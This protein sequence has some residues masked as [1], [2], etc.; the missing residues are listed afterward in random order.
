MEGTET[1]AKPRAGFAAGFFFFLVFGGIMQR[2]SAFDSFS[3]F[4]S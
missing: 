3:T 2:Y 1:V 4:A